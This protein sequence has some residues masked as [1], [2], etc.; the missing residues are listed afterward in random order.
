[1]R[2]LL[3]TVAALSLL[4]AAC[5]NNGSDTTQAAPPET[6]TTATA[7]TTTTA[8]ATTTTSTTTSVPDDTAT[9]IGDEP[10]YTVMAGTPQAE[11]DSF[12]AT[13]EMTFDLGELTVDMSTEGVWTPEAFSCSTTT[14]MFGL[15]IEQHVVATPYQAWVDTGFGF[16]PSSLDDP[17]T[18][19]VVETCPA[20]P[21]F[22]EQFSLPGGISGLTSES[23]D[24]N[25]I[26][27]QR[28]DLREAVEGFGGLGLVPALEGVSF[29]T[30]TT[31]ISEDGYVVALDM[32]VGIDEAA[33]ADTGI[34]PELELDGP[35]EMTMRFELA[36]ANDPD[37]VV[38]LPE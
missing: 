3:A 8:A 18:A 13:M 23:D 10:I 25:G 31:W 22:W 11:L 6:T 27:A 19:S 35:G 38:D 24:V 20:A 15:G 28:I 16:E 21:T 17:D 29:D 14:N 2:R 4:G 34:P 36:D 12:T 37:L 33:L 5:S 9:T 32:A 1:M 26:P 30:F 7:T